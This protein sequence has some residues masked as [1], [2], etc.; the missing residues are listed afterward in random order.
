M[1]GIYVRKFGTGGKLHIAHGKYPAQNPGK[2]AGVEPKSNKRKKRVPLP[3]LIPADLLFSVTNA[4][5]ASCVVDAGHP[6]D[7]SVLCNDPNESPL[8]SG[9]ASLP[10][11]MELSQSTVESDSVGSMSIGQSHELNTDAQAANVFM[12]GGNVLHM[13]IGEYELEHGN[14]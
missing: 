2:A 8:A 3:P 6:S 12:V 13:S 7:N 1:N 11:V 5:V 4:T 14:W 10:H 9:V